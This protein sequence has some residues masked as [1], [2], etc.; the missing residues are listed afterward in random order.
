MATKPFYTLKD[1]LRR[2]VITP[3]LCDSLTIW[4]RRSGRI[5]YQHTR[6]HEIS[7]DGRTMSIRD[8]VE[9]MREVLGYV[10]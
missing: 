8:G 6:R 4:Y 5:A 3:L 2:S 7:V 9:K 1:C 10:K